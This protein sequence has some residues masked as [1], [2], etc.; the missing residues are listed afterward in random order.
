MLQ[1]GS[2]LQSGLYRLAGT[3]TCQ[4]T[5]SAIRILQ[6]PSRDMLH[7]VIVTK[8]KLDHNTDIEAD[9]CRDIATLLKHWYIE[10]EL[11]RMGLGNN[12]KYLFIG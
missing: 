1:S 6:T 2:V 3:G 8:L 4:E 7:N 10:H 9:T 5:A 12:R 11:T